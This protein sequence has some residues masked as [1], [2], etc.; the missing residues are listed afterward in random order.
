MT[1]VRGR[2]RRRGRYPICQAVMVYAAAA[3]ASAN[4][5]FDT[6]SGT[7]G[8]DNRASGCFSH[9]IDDFVGPVRDCKRI[10]KGFGGSK[11]S[12]VKIG[13]LKWSWEDDKGLKTTHLISNS[14]YSQLGGVRLLSPQHF[15]QVSSNKGPRAGSKTTAKDITLY[16]GEGATKTVP[17]DERNNVATFHLSPGYNNFELFCMKAEA[18]MSASSPK[19]EER[20]DI[21]D[22]DVPQLEGN[23]PKWNLPRGNEF[24]FGSSRIAQ[25]T[26]LEMKRMNLESELLQIHCNMGHIH[27]DRLKVMAKQGVIPPKY[28]HVRMPFCAACAHGKATRK[29][30]RSRIPNN[31]DETERKNT[32]GE[33]VSV[34]QMISPTPGLVAQMT[35][36]LTSKRYTCTTIDRKSVV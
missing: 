35:G 9:V 22:R 1:R 8:I 12:N 2:P 3:R 34:D 30:W 13:T 16:W 20:E 10:V 31:K 11:T 15:A 33:T 23:N 21:D 24:R 4:S 19:E 26:Q 28:Q 5:T 25:S 27:P 29:P 7:V 17:L 14:Y 18:E 6:D 32:P 36:M